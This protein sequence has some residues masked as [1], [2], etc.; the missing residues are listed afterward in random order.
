[1]FNI[2]QQTHLLFLE[3]FLQEMIIFVSSNTGM[4][5][6][7]QVKFKTRMHSSRMRTIRS[8]TI[9]HSICGGGGCMAGGH[10]WQGGGVHGRRHACLAC[11]L[12]DMHTPHYTHTLPCTPPPCMSPA[13]HAPPPS[14]MPLPA[15]HA[16]PCHACPPVDR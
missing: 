5:K 2:P 3:I 1:M 13:T 10:A 11:P 15:M 8:L 9:S 7:I 12:A 14:C 4:Y 6:N 16:P